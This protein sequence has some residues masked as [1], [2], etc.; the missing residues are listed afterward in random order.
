MP[1]TAVPEESRKAVP[2]NSLLSC[3][4]YKVI[5]FILQSCAPCPLDDTSYDG[6]T[7]ETLGLIDGLHIDG[8]E[9]KMPP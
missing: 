5:E 4:F 9:S 2:F 7:R 6:I 3:F 1:A 8:V